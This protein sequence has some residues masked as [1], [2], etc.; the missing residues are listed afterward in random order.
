MT[1]KAKGHPFMDP[2]D[3]FTMFREWYEATSETWA[4][5]VNGTIGT[6]QFIES[7]SPFLE[8]YANFY[9]TTRR[10][11]EE[12]FKNLQLPTR[13][14]IARVAELIVNLEEK[15]D[16][17]ED[18]L[19]TMGTMATM[20]TVEQVERLGK[21]LEA[22]EGKLDRVIAAIEQSSATAKPTAMPR[23]VPAKKPVKPD[24]GKERQK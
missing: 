1:E 10:A 21:R 4:E 5:M 18:D 3:I 9:K 12:Y 24:E 8:S 19:A 7:A 11:N 23:S 15:V 17:M 2:S 22:I 16:G 20:A 14:D 13:S 6:E